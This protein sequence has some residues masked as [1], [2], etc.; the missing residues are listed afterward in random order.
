LDNNFSELDSIRQNSLGWRNRIINGRMEINQR[1]TSFAAGYS[2]FTLD[3][4]AALV[5]GGGF[6]TITQQFDAPTEFLYSLRAT[7]TTADTSLTTTDIG[8]FYTRLEGYTV[9]DLIGKSFLMSF[10][11]RS[12]KTGIH[13][14]AFR[15][16]IADR[17]FVTEYTINA[18]NNWEYKTVF[19][20]GGLITAGSWDWT[21]NTGLDVSFVYAC[22]P[23]YRGSSANTW[24][25]GN[26]VATANQ[27]NCLDTVGNIFA[28]TGV[29]LEPGTIATPFEHKP[30]NVELI[31]SSRYYQRHGFNIG[32]VMTTLGRGVTPGGSAIWRCSLP[33]TAPLRVMPNVTSTA[34][35]AWT[36]VSGPFP[37]SSFNAIY[38]TYISG[39]IGNLEADI[40]VSA[41][42]TNT[43]GIAFLQTNNGGGAS[44]IEYDSEMT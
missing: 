33:L 38:G 20:P 14:C 29:Q 9:R 2:G 39:S 18:A 37:I 24:L 26:F 13:C 30:F 25:T 10:W 4:W 8:F 5:G 6:A 43:G 1:G 41:S 27:V 19:V 23:T 17:S 11:V 40:G 3:R 31:N 32:T 7:V 16:K 42:L 28:I 36:P 12:S 15:N 34:L 35:Y 22:G 21:N 44:Y